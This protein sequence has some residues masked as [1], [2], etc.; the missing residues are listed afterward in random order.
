MRD[1]NMRARISQLHRTAAEWNK[2]P[3]FVPMQSELIVYDPDSQ[4]SYARI[5]VGDGVTK[6]QK[7]PFIVDSAM[8]DF[9]TNHNK[10]I[11]AGRVTDYLK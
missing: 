8:S 11:D 9:I 7:L 1:S 4:Y 2:L 6:L 3:D 10:I 5:K